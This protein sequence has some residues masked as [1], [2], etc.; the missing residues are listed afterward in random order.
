MSENKNGISGKFITESV[1]VLLILFSVS[2]IFLIL[3]HDIFLNLKTF[4]MSL[5]FLFF[6]LVVIWA[7][8]AMFKRRNIGRL[9]A[10]GCLLLILFRQIQGIISLYS[11]G[12][13][14]V[15]P[16]FLLISSIGA[17]PFLSLALLTSGLIYLLTTPKVRIFFKLKTNK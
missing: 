14:G 13:E 1:G 9:T 2:L 7:S 8:V 6:N 10:I 15:I 16:L 4:F 17:L 3:S 5:A 11:Y 12:E